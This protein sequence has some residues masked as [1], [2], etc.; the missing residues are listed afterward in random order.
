MG[1]IG[2]REFLGPFFDSG[3][4]PF[5]LTRLTAETGG[6]FIAVHPFRVDAGRANRGGAGRDELV[7]KLRLLLRSTVDAQVSTRLCAC[8]RVS[9]ATPIE[10]GTA[11]FGRSVHEVVDRTSGRPRPVR[12]PAINEAQLAESLTQAQRRP[13]LLEPKLFELVE[14]LR[15]G[16]R[17]RAELDSPRWQ[18]GFDLAMGRALAAKVRNEGYNAMLAQ[19]KNGLEFQERTKRHLDH[20][21]RA[22]RL[23]AIAD[24]RP[25]PS[26]RLP[27]LSAWPKSIPE[28]LGDARSTRT[29]GPTWLAMERSF[30]KP[31][32]T[33]TAAGQSTSTP[34]P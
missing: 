12:V 10:P 26:K 13:A 9:K 34:T 28:P 23:L 29:K 17:D 31:S 25:K 15:R 7:A 27:I 19:A 21:A 30:Q 22:K 20:F 11:G 3:F 2:G 16:E 18:A 1:V 5:G 4:G 24:L 32:R 6:F 8:G 14:T 33:P